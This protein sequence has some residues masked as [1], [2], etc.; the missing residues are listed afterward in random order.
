[1]IKRV[2]EQKLNFPKKKNDALCLFGVKKAISTTSA[3]K[4]DN[5][6]KRF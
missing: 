5:D 4:N 2:S 3:N 6:K 1:M